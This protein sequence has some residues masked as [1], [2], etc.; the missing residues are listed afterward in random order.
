[1]THIIRLFVAVSAFGAAFALATSLHAQDA[2]G[3]DEKA[4]PANP[5]PANPA[6]AKKS[7]ATGAKPAEAEAFHPPNPAVDTIVE[8]NPKTPRDLLQAAVSLAALDRPDLAKRYINQLLASEASGP[9]L[10]DLARHFGSATLMQLA[11]DK[12][13][14]P[15]SKQLADKVLAAAAVE[16]HEPARLA[17]YIKQLS[18]PSPDKQLEAV[19]AMRDAGPRAVP[20][21]LASI[22]DPAQAGTHALAREAVIGM[23]V[24]AT[25]PLIAAVGATDPAVQAAAI[26]LLADLGPQPFVVND[27]LVPYL[28]ERSNPEVRRAAKIALQ[29]LVGVLPNRMDAIALLE[30]EVRAYLRRERPLRGDESPLVAVWQWDPAA[31][32]VVMAEYPPDRASA[33]I[34]ARLAGE[35]LE[36]SPNIAEHR[37]LFLISMLESAVYRVG[38]DNPLPRGAGTEY[39]LAAQFGVE[40]INDALAEALA[41]GNTTAAKG[42]A[43]ILGDLGDSRFLTNDGQPAPL[44]RALRSHDR[45]LRVAAAAAIMK[46]KPSAP[47]A[48]SSWL[49]DTL[50]EMAASTGRRGAAI[51]FPTLAP[52]QQLA[53]MT[54]ALGLQT[55]TGTTGRDLFA[56]ATQSP[57]V[58][59]ILVSARLNHSTAVEV[60]QQLRED[61]RTADVPIC[62]MAELDERG[63]AE[64]AMAKFPGVFVETRPPSLEAM[65]R[66]VARAAALAQDHFV[67]AKLRQQE[68]VVAL[69]WLAQLAVLPPEIADVRH[70]EPTIVRA[71]YSPLTTAHAAAVLSRLPTPLSQRS[72]V[73]LASTGAQPLAM[74]QASA[75]AFAQ[76][77]RQFGVRLAPSEIALQY[78]RYNQSAALDKPTQQLLGGLLDVIEKKGTRD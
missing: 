3:P 5:A 64:Q 69:D 11:G 29:R 61:P 43:Q 9:A 35:L 16:R 40:S 62:V 25:P 34:A 39:D 4:G 76:S 58:E 33:F 6:P 24:G 68:A 2:K 46:F 14:N 49:T 18:D 48:G 8:S 20:L 47:F 75:A 77:V 67:P 44:V 26:G 63:F 31:K 73:D 27:L 78:D 19:T 53:G 21:L 60:V 1:M 10:A 36:L 55:Q 72:L 28:S 51:G 54:N 52:L 12:S 74:R 15:Q 30:R 41:T 65:Q 71:L 38:L 17:A 56:A 13:L 50:A 42:A 32:T 70:Y 7:P 22:A 45:R 23:G 37:R 59:L 57:D 66:I